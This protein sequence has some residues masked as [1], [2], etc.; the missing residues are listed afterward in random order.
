MRKN[1]WVLVF[2]FILFLVFTTVF[3]PRVFANRHAKILGVAT[4]SQQLSIPPTVE[5]PGLILPDSPLF[6]LDELKQEARIYTAITPETKAQI[7]KEIAGER[8]AELRFMLARNNKQGVELTLDG[9]KNNLEMAVN[10]VNQAQ[11]RGKNVSK[12]AKT[13]NDSIKEKQEVLDQLQSQTT[14]E[15]KARI[16]SVQES[17]LASKIKGE[18]SLAL[19]DLDNEIRYDLARRIKSGVRETIDSVELLQE[20]ID[21]LNNQALEASKQMLARREEALNKTIQQKNE[22]LVKTQEQLLNQE[23]EK[24]TKLLGA[25]TSAL[26]QAKE[27]LKAASQAAD[28][29]GKTQAILDGEEIPTPQATGTPTPTSSP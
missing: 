5:G 6:F 8:F 11:M 24:Q 28:E 21:E 17:L 12:L 16:E 3:T 9:V 26:D 20:Q 18:D 14:G 19:A 4:T 13:I 15:L 29:F 2:F 1:S 23:K 25:Q 7:Y 27:A 22:A 10:E